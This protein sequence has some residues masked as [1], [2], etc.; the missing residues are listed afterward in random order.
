MSKPVD[1]VLVANAAHARACRTGDPEKIA[2]TK[3][4]VVEAKLLRA[5]R[6]ALSAPLP[7][8]AEARDAIARLLVDDAA[9]DRLAAAVVVEIENRNGGSS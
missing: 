7:P 8:S 3:R 6:E 1:P 4:A 9:L 5:V 2:E